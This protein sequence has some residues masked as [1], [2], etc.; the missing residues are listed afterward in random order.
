VSTPPPPI[1]PLLPERFAAWFAA[2]GWTLRPHQAAMLEA[3]RAA[4]PVLLVAPT[5]A[6][7]TLSGFLPSLVDLADP[8]KRPKLGLTARG[9]RRKGIHTLYVS[10]L[11]ALAV[12]VARNLEVPIAEMGLAIT[13]ETRT[14][15]TPAHKRQRQKYDPPDILMTTPEQVALLLASPEAPDLFG[16]LKRVVFDELH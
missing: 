10:P 9:V 5:G 12:D 14:G 15:D 1:E 2:R 11:K 8:A 7:K 3:A 4:R 13:V 6:G 16:S